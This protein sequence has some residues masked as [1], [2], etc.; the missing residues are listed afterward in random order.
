MSILSKIKSFFTQ[1]T[2]SICSVCLEEFDDHELENIES[3]SLCPSHY[4]L[5]KSSEHKLLKRIHSTPESPELGVELYN[6]QKELLRKG[7]FTYIKSHYKEVDG[8]I[9]TIQEL[10]QI[11]KRPSY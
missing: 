11:L 1:S 8:Y 6:L 7:T 9:Q 10:Y 4:I 2:V 5:Y 3:L